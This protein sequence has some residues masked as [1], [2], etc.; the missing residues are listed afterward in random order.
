[1][2]DD[3]AP[4]RYRFGPLERRG[5]VAGWRG[6]QIAV[7]ASG[8]V[9]AVGILRARPSAVGVAVALVAVA[10]GVAA[11]TWPFGGRTAEEWAP[12]AARHLDAV[13][14]QRKLRRRAPFA[15]LRFL[16]VDLTATT[17]PSLTRAHRGRGD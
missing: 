14:R 16:S 13:R 2:A 17:A 9:V 1:M 7:V 6:G 10:A 8:L 4:P 12:E 3:D 15:T 5:L 11:A